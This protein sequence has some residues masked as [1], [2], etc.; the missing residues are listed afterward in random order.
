MAK[1]YVSST[2]LDL[3]DCR[4]Q[5]E[6]VIRR[7]GHEDVAMEYY[8]AEDQRPVDKCLADVAACD[9]YVG[10]FAWRY[11]WVPKKDN[12]DKLSITEMEYR[13]AI[14][15]GKPCWVFLLSDEAPWPPKFIDKNRK[16]IEKLRDGVSA[17]HLA[18]YFKSVD[19][20]GRLVAE[21]IHKYEKEH[22]YISPGPVIHEFDLEAYYGALRKRYQTL[23]LEGL[24]PP[25]KEEYLQLQLRSVFVEQNVRESPPPVELPKEVWGK[26]EREREIH[27]EDLPAGI[28][29][30][31]VRRAREA[32][33]EKPS[34]PVLDVLTDS[35]Y[36]QVIILGDP[37][38]GKSTLA[39]YVLLAL[40]D[41]TGDGKLRRAF[42]G[43][44]PLLVE[45]RSYASLCDD[46]KCNNFLEFLEYLG[47]TEGWH[48]TQAALHNHLKNDGHAVVIFDGLDEIFAPQE[49]EQIT[50]Q[51]V[52][53]AHNYPKAR[54]VVT[55][56]VIGY[57]RKILA[58]AGFA[59]F[60]LQDLDE[61]QVATFADRWYGL[62]MSDRP[63]EAKERRERILRSFEES[64]S[65]R[66]LAGNPMLLT[67]MAII[68]KHQELPR[69]RWKLYDH[70]ASVLIQHWDVNKHLRDQRIDADLI[71]E[72]D[73]K[74]L[75]RRL[76]FKMQGGQG[77]LAGNYIHREQLEAEFEDYL[78]QRY[79]Q[80]LPEAA[81]IAR[82]MIDQFRERNF[83]L[84]LYGANLYGFVHRAF[85]EYF[86]ASAFV[87]KFEKTQEM[88][89]EQLKREVYGAHWEDESWHEV[90]RLICGM[91]DEKWAGEIIDYLA[92]EVY[93][94]WPEKFGDRPPW[95][96]VL[97][98]QCLGEVRNLNTVAEP[99]ERLL[100]VVCSLFQHATIDAAFAIDKFLDEQIV[101]TSGVISASWPHRDM[102]SGWLQEYKAP[103]YANFYF[104]SFARFVASVG[105]G[106]DD[107]HRVLL[108]YATHK[109]W[110]YRIFA[111]SALAKGWRD[112]PQTLPLVRDG[113]VNDGDEDVR[114]AAVRALA[115][116]FRDDPQTLPLVRDR[117]VNDAHEDA[118]SAAVRALDEHFRDDPQ[119]LL[120]VHD[121]AVNDAHEDVR[122]A[123]V[124]A[125]VEHFHDDPQTLPLVRD[126]AVNDV[127]EDVRSAA[128]RALAEYWRDDP[129]TLPLV[130]DRA[131]NDAH[132]WVCSA[133]VQVLAEHCRDDPQTLPLVRDRAINDAHEGVRS[134]AVYALAEHF[135]DDPQTLPLVCDRAVNDAHEWVRS[136]A[137]SALAEHFRD[138]PQTLPLVRDRAV[139]DAHEDVRSA[140][141][142]ALVE[143]FH[144][145]PQTLPLVRDRA[146]ND[147]HERVR[148]AAVRALTEH[149]RDDPQTLPLVRD[150]A[151]NDTNEWVRFAAVEALAE[152]WRDD[153]QTLP[154]VR[155]RAVN[156]AHE[157]VRS[158][159]VEALA[160]H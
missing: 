101:P 72:D 62:A 33:Y 144:D 20:L 132:E 66:Q 93:R 4:R 134:A 138:D 91:I 140:A 154:L 159:A 106:L 38:S 107:I 47:Q 90:L 51:I 92:N 82:A 146:V 12:P 122:S 116:H 139:N 117:A 150:R 100:K 67:I 17:E 113:A 34:R 23:A 114:S 9:V 56:R 112:D 2:Y 29:L 64:A 87:W 41:P 157:R 32:Y 119:T 75:L 53:F 121:R 63:D 31:D 8:V 147:A 70:A 16:K 141:V 55:S 143:H 81:K 136:A 30:E 126:R 71:G 95:N 133:A 142:S 96:I 18:G 97:A 83:I 74:E 102:L 61:K 44:L 85:L 111:P 153:P 80:P 137:V 11:G 89:L 25:Q 86:C 48:L 149:W 54:V 105:T 65:I 98:V 13:Q 76:A 118:R 73:K 52:G 42:E 160:E 78:M 127:H 36:R 156:D 24:T 129:Q 3:Q 14:K 109:Q 22:G 110:N 5:V 58:D 28:A 124:S 135:R 6:L 120:L 69:E 68:G 1:I 94:P 39:R 7:M 88:T 148:S 123:A 131:V 77:G 103:T 128:V 104:E 115:E 27:P 125:L 49:R 152:H 99:A 158:A 84:S 60:T 155:D 59:H 108:N 50:R 46:G 26:L 145:D 151:V 43:Y 10:V 37:G 19:D 21:A 15:H 130:R 45:L 79:Q 40:I 57:W 35:R